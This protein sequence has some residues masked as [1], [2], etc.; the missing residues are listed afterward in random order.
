MALRKGRPFLA[1]LFGLALAE[2]ILHL[3]SLGFQLPSPPPDGTMCRAAPYV[4]YVCPVGGD[5]HDELFGPQREQPSGPAVWMFG[6]STMLG[7]VGERRLPAMLA[8]VL[9]EGGQPHV[10]RNFGQPGYVLTQ[11]R[12]LFEELLTWQAPPK[13]AIFYDGANQ[14]MFPPVGWPNQFRQLSDNLER[15]YSRNRFVTGLASSRFKVPFVLDFLLNSHEEEGAPNPFGAPERSHR[16]MSVE[17]EARSYLHEARVL[18]AVCRTYG[19]TCHVVW[20]PTVCFK[21][22]ASEAERSAA[23][24]FCANGFR[25][26]LRDELRKGAA[27]TPDVSFVDLS[28]LF[29]DEAAPLYIDFCHFAD[30]SDGNLR[31][32]R[33]MHERLF[34]LTP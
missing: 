34:A 12:I 22:P 7:R 31:V 25:E 30:D 9:G 1:L 19:V 18:A 24:S 11:E 29:R 5:V 13:V 15:R 20:Q 17:D 28:E 6:G 23:K 33:A 32:A 2:G 10:V 14:G 21:K 16:G 3:A 4:D 27:A 8:R 26:S